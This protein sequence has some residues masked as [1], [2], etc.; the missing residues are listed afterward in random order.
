[1]AR[2][3]AAVAASACRLG[4]FE[5]RYLEVGG[6]GLVEREGA[7]AAY[8][9]TRFEDVPPVRRFP[10]YQGQRSFSGLYFAACMGRHV[11]FES[12]LERDLYRTLLR[13]TSV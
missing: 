8:W 9:S 1:M 13:V 2:G 4:G 7:L 5:L 10:S 6:T 11:G 3:A 12:W